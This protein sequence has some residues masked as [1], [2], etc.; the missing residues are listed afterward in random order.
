MPSACPPTASH[1]TLSLRLG[2][3]LSHLQVRCCDPHLLVLLGSSKTG[4]HT[5]PPP[6]EKQV[7][8]SGPFPS[9]PW[10]WGAPGPQGLLPA[11]PLHPPGVAVLQGLLGPDPPGRLGLDSTT[12]HFHPTP[13][14]VLCLGFLGFRIFPS[15][16]TRETRTGQGV[17]KGHTW[18]GC[19]WAGG[20]PQGVSVLI[21]P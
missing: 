17:S 19:W 21:L 20:G 2:F 9:A 12:Q 5:G 15:A 10:L 6:T 11:A 4:R 1:S 3:F 8:V 18:G 16:L 14:S 13:L 7:G